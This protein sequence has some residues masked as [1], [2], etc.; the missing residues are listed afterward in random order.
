MLLR[1][2]GTKDWIGEQQLRDRERMA[3]TRRAILDEIP[4]ARHQQPLE[5]RPP[6]PQLP[7]HLR[8]LFGRDSAI[9]LER[10][11]LAFARESQ[12]R[13]SAWTRF[14]HGTQVRLVE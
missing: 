8:R 14:D 3:V 1:E 4:R 11:A 5:L 13:R 10:L 9:D 6:R 2:P 12:R 7:L